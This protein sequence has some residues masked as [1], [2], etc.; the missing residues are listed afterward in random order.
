[1]SK[2]NELLSYI[3]KLRNMADYL[4]RGY[5]LQSSDDDTAIEIVD[6]EMTKQRNAFSVQEYSLYDELELSYFGE[7]RS[8]GILMEYIEEGEYEKQV[9]GKIDFD[10]PYIPDAENAEFYKRVMK[11]INIILKMMALSLAS[12]SRIPLETEKFVALKKVYLDEDELSMHEDE[13]SGSLIYDMERQCFCAIN[14]EGEII[15][16]NV[17][18]N[19]AM[20]LYNRFLL[21]QEQDELYKKAIEQENRNREETDQEERE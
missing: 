5:V 15:V 19:V 11:R 10:E 3:K 6:D 7:Q 9:E 20:N 16:E 2:E 4:A 8:I 14:S 12:G 18:I 17:D 21:I 1:M 13:K